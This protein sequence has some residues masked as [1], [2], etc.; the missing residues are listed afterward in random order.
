MA[1]RPK[2]DG[3]GRLGGRAPGTPNKTNAAT[4]TAIARIVGDYLTPTAEAQ[5][6]GVKH[7][8][9]EDLDQLTPAE[10]ARIITGLAAYVVPKQQSLSIDDQKRIEVDALTTWLETAPAEA[11]DGIAAKVLELQAKARAEKAPS[12]PS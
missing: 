10:R 11:I 1:G 9:D 2:G 3:K 12:Q 5:R 6:A 8:L 7:T 4:K